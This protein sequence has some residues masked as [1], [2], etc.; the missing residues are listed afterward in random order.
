[1]PLQMWWHQFLNHAHAWFLEITFVREVGMRVVCVS[2]PQAVK[3]Y[4][5][6][7]KSEWPIK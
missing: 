4:S 6:E 7:M 1:M 3:N 2:A 5:R